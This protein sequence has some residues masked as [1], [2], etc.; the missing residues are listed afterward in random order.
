MGG[1]VCL[2]ETDAVVEVSR[3]VEEFVPYGKLPRI[4]KSR[5]VITE[6]IDGTNACVVIRGGEVVLV[7]SRKR[8]IT[9]EADNFGFAAWV[10]DNS[11]LLIEALGEG[12][13]YGEWAGPGIQKNP[14]DIMEKRFFLFNTHQFP[15]DRMYNIQTVICPTV[16]LD[17]VPTIVNHRTFNLSVIQEAM[18]ELM[19]NGTQVRGAGGGGKAEGVV[20]SCFGQKFKCTV[21]DRH[22][23]ERKND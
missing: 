12:R 19:D 23:W 13:H 20:V 1:S 5:M 10:R 9:P 2:P 8:A 7:Q 18:D 11:R 14:H 4:H 22:K 6:K 3:G 21:D 15:R 17:V 16:S